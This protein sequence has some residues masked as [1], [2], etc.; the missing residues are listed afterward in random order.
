MMEEEINKEEIQPVVK[1]SDLVTQFFTYKG[2]VK[3]IDGVSFEIKPGEVLGLVGESGCGKSVTATSIMDL[4]PDPPGR[5]ISGSIYIDGYNILADLKKQAKIIVKSE[6]NVKI[7]RNKRE[8]KNHGFIMSK[9]RGDKISMIFQEPSLSMN[10]VM[11]I[12]DQIEEAILLHSKIEIANGIIRRETM[13]DADIDNM[14]KEAKS[15]KTVLETRQFINEWTRIYGVPEAEEGI[16]EIL[17][18]NSPNERTELI[19]LMK[20]QKTGVKLKYITMERDYEKYNN[21]LFELS[22]KLSEA[23][24]RNDASAVRDLQ[25]QIKKTKSYINSKFLS[26]RL[27]KRF[28]GRRIEEPFK[29]AARRRAMELLKLVNIAGPERVI[30]SYPHELSGG[31]L[32]RSMI[33][34]ALSSN[35]KVLIADEPTTALDVTTQAQILDIMR[36]LNRVM[37]TSILFITHDLAVIAEMCN[38]VAVMYAGNIVEEADV[39]EIF[40]NPKHPYTVG[41]LKSIPRPDVTVDK[42]EKLE[43]IKGS[44][45]NLITPP[46]GCRFNPRCPFAMDICDKEKPKL[47][48]IGNNH[49]VA[50]FLFSE[51]NKEA[52]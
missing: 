5:I 49:K 40:K 43:S 15:K 35:P 29:K 32:Q 42:F 39:K 33:A 19:N 10:P 38:R 44:V 18:R 22:L 31:M 2:I 41:L 51:N 27:I 24:I 9:I 50:C 30:D 1:V 17:E 21:L 3:A 28:I 47:V 12:G 48:D 4:I 45:P 36:D 13:T 16:L 46:T 34:M 20:E 8:I 6:T 23:E 14:I 7:K 11:R 52:N 37:K 26:Y 25:N